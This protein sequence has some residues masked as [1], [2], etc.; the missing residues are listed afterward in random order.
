MDL[1]KRVF[2]R[3]WGREHRQGPESQ[4]VTDPGFLDL[5]E[6]SSRK[7]YFGK[8]SWAVG[9]SYSGEPALRTHC[10]FRLSKALTG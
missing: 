6:D 5:Y 8:E 4:S 1:L 2:E 10:I 3:A 9:E 7:A